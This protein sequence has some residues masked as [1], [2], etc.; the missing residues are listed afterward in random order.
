MIISYCFG[1]AD[2]IHF[3][4]INMIRK[5]AENSDLTIFGLVS[6][7]ASEAWFG[8]HVSNEDERRVVLESIK[9]IDE[10]WPQLTFDPLE[11]LRKIHLKYPDAE[12]HLY[13][14]N[15]WGI[16]PAKKYIE[17]IGG[18]VIKLEYYDKL[19]PQ[20]I[21][22]TLNKNEMQNK[23]LNNNLISTKAN[24]LQFLK[25]ILSKARIEDLFIVT[26]GSFKDNK[27]TVAVAIRSFFV[28]GLIVVR[29][30]SKREDAFEESNAGHFM[31]ILNV[32]ASDDDSIKRA[33]S[34]VILSYGEDID[35]DEQVL[36]Q[37]QTENV[38]AS[39]VVFTRDIQRNR[40]YY[41]INYDL[42]G[43]T[44]SVTSGTGGTS[45]WMSHFVSKDNVPEKWKSLMEA[46]WEIENL[47]SGILLDIEFAITP[48]SV[49][50]FQVRPLA[51]AY[52]FGRKNNDQ[53]VELVKNEAIIKYQK[54]RNLG[55][56]CFSDMA[57]WN[58]AEIIGDN[59][60]NLDFSLYREII[61]K[62]SWN[63][64]LI[65][66]GYRHVPGELMYRFGNKPYI[67]V[68]KSFYALIPSALSDRLATK[69]KDY[70]VMKLKED[71]SA[72]DKIEFEISHNCFDFSMHKRLTQL[73]FDGFTTEELSELENALKTLTIKAI[74]TYND[75]LTDDISDLKSLEGIRLDIKNI[76][77]DNS[78]YR[79]IAKSI[80]TL[81]EAIDKFGTPQ[82]SRHA[83]CA[84]IAKS[85]CKSLVNEGYI[86]QE[87]YNHF[88]SSIRTIAVYYDRDYHS[89]LE[90]KMTVDDFCLTYGHLRAGTY[91]IR[92]PRYDQMEQL[93]IHETIKDEDKEI[94]HE[95]IDIDAR[96]SIAIEK[97]LIDAQIGEI[98]GDEVINFIKQAT[99]QREY[100][101]FVFTKSLSFAIELIKQ[102]GQL[103]GIGVNDLS[104][105]EVPEIYASEYYSDL[106][107]LCE[108]WNLI[109]NK[110]RELFKNNSEMILPAVIY[111]EQDFNYIENIES[112]PNFITDSIIT[113]LL[114]LLEDDSE[115]SIDGKI[116]VI[117]KADP[118]YDWIFSKG[119]IGLVTKYGGAAS[120]M[121]IRC[122]EFKIPAAIGC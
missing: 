19:S 41:V 90:G 26:V 38:I 6:D 86:S 73:Q 103:T 49:V 97:A 40:P 66:M 72:H 29:S 95:D 83:R 44:D 12:M 115:E 21:L 100:F 1:M 13:T 35:D 84:F 79:V 104:Y 27:N 56:T 98:T 76:T 43:S 65:P 51:A 85:L 32:D 14:G 68:E 102:M 80:H 53:E 42:S 101:K 55:L 75:V 24:T 11:N 105:I 36:V 88:I 113:G 81:L 30:S 63:I 74:S 5:A 50:I 87:E 110:R 117:E 120:H 48:E 122:A 91:N 60:K 96:M 7:E 118:G 64:G 25:G 46:V 99:E 8:A 10:V 45:A 67:S 114:V 108:F 106:D 70:Y 59:P 20:A 93:F 62:S 107:R 15:E 52:K 71:L 31:S 2:L 39:G 54:R 121:A 109:I 61:T 92:S 18:R 78:D 111:S 37:R 22:D 57:F 89:V 4:H 94:I 112:R 47:L 33:I 116:V 82:F 23:P 34:T 17:S 28:S 16:L 58:P 77:K 9:Y 69:L 3:G 119:I